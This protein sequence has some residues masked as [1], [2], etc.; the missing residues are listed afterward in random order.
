LR[1]RDRLA[2]IMSIENDVAF[3][4]WAF[5]QAINGRRRSRGGPGCGFKAA[6]FQ[7]ALQMRRGDGKPLRVGR[8]ALLSGKLIQLTDDRGLRPAAEMRTA[9]SDSLGQG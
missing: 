7:Q 2:I 4:L 9:R 8:D 1:R 5:E 6:L 3:C